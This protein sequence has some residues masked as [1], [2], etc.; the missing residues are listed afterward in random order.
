MQII[1]HRGS[2]EIG[3]SC[4]EIIHNKSRIIVDIGI[5]LVDSVGNKFDA[6][7]YKK[8]SGQELVKQGV[9]PELKGVYSWD[10]LYEKVDGMLLSHPHQ[11]HYGYLKYVDKIIPFYL[12]EAAHKLIELTVLFTQMEGKIHNPH[13]IKSGIPFNCGEF[14]ITPYLMDHSAFDAYAFL[15]EAGGKRLFY[16]GDFRSHGRKEKTF[17]WFLHNAPKNIDALLLEGTSFGRNK[18]EYLAETEIEEEMVKIEQQTNGLLLVQQSGQNIDRLV[19]FYRA[20]V[21]SGRLFVIDVYIANV[22]TALKEFARLPYPSADFEN[23]RVFFPWYLCK[24]IKEKNRQELMYRFKQYKITKEEIA[25]NRQQI[26]LL[27]RPSMLLDLK[28]IKAFTQSAYVYSLW[29]GYLN[30]ERMKMVKK[31]LKNNKIKFYQ[32]HTSGHAS[33]NTLKE[34]VKQLRPAKI[35]PIHTFY[36]EQYKKLNTNIL[37]VSDGE[38]ISI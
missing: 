9:L 12:G 17:K 27:V 33:I 24:Q 32:L 38:I 19:S 15:I 20:A 5:P 29:S 21:K 2:H 31:F 18:G 37:T 3:G 34:M 35:I 1:I 30:D 6:A 22:L 16:S 13:Y 26:M 25:R 36:P 14:K 8:N 7:R 4:V 11:D 23:I 28:K 10:D